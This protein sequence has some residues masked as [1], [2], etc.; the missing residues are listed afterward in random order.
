MAV[1]TPKGNL[2]RISNG[3]PLL[4]PQQETYCRLRIAGNSRAQAYNL[5]YNKPDGHKYGRQS[6]ARL[7]KSHPDILD[8]IRAIQQQAVE[9]SVTRLQ[10]ENDY[11]LDTYREIIERCMQSRPV[12]SR[13][14]EPTGEYRFDART[15]VA[16]LNS[17]AKINGLY[18]NDGKGQSEEAAKNEQQLL[19]EYHRLNEQLAEVLEGGDSGEARSDPEGTDEAEGV[20]LQPIPEAG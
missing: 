2:P 4:N 12:V 10:I 9:R 8:R 5:A 14:G 19:E 6:A 20:P 7:E 18:V 16:A 17:L 11:I 1:K 15:A 3:K 13:E